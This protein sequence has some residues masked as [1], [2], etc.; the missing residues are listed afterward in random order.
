M[1]VHIL[2]SIILQG[3]FHVLITFHE[4]LQITC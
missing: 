1:I 3:M 4:P 2:F